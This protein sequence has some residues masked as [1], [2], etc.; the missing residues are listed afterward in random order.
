LVH[1]YGY[2][3]AINCCRCD[4]C[5]LRNSPVSSLVYH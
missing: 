5:S 1:Y 2:F 3:L 4:L